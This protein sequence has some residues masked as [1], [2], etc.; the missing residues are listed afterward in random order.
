MMP[1][2]ET[3]TEERKEDR[4]T[5]PTFLCPFTIGMFEETRRACIGVRCMAF[6]PRDPLNPELG[7]ICARCFSRWFD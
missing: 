2:Q 5:G 6:L 3:Q 4:P 1:Q 7:G